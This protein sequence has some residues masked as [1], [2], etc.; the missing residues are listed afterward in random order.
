MKVHVFF[1][2][3]KENILTFRTSDGRQGSEPLNLQKESVIECI[4]RLR[5][6]LQLS[7]TVQFE[8][9]SNRIEI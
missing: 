1:Y 3:T 5:K 4:T 8:C 2:V 9:V 7:D 6:Q